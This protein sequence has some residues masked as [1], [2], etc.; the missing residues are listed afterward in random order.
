M[1]VDE[2]EVADEE[3]GLHRFG[4]DAEGLGTEGDDEDRDDDEVE[5]GLKRGEN[6]GLVVVVMERVAGRSGSDVGWESGL[7]LASAG[8]GDVELGL[9]S[10]PL[11]GRI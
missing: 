8:V 2:E 4:G 3:G 7:G 6:A 11:S 5:E 9:D 10:G 1:L